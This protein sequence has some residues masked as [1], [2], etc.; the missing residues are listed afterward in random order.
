MSWTAPLAEAPT[1]QAAGLIAIAMATIIGVTLLLHWIFAAVRSADAPA[2]TPVQRRKKSTIDN[3][4]ATNQTSLAHSAPHAMTRKVLL[5]TMHPRHYE[6][7]DSTPTRADIVGHAESLPA[8]LMLYLRT[9]K[10]APGH[11]INLL[12]NERAGARRLR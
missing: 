9:R 2:G 5:M 1:G 10:T 11:T 6:V 12:M 4:P 3:L 8:A 7:W